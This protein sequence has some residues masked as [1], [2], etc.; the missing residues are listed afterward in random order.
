MDFVFLVSK[1][2]C[3]FYVRLPILVAIKVL[4]GIIFPL[5]ILEHLIIKE[6]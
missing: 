4:Q 1:M 5:I 2:D 3:F 6:L